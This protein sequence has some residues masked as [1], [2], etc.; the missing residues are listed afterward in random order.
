MPHLNKKQ[1]SYMSYTE[2]ELGS[3]SEFNQAELEQLAAKER[4]A[5]IDELN[6]NISIN[7]LPSHGGY[8]SGM[9]M[10]EMQAPS[11]KQAK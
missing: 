5:V 3:E 7:Q 4:G 10:S 6:S 2:P 11:K 9:P 1:N 8:N